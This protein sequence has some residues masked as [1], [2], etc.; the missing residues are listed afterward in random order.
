[1]NDASLQIHDPNLKSAEFEVHTVVA[2]KSFI[3]QNITGSHD[4]ISQKR[5]F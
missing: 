5:E 1:V 4:I 2:M 3:F